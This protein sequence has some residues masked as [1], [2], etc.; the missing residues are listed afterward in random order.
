[1]GRGMLPVVLSLGGGDASFRQPIAI[2]VIGGRQTSTVLSLI[3]TPVVFTFVDN[4]RP[5]LKPIFRKRR[6][7]DHW[8]P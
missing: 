7:A 2:V 5:L 1:M 3:V 4:Y 6:Q 8:F